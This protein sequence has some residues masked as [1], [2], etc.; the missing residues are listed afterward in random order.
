MEG[1]AFGQP[2]GDAEILIEG[3]GEELED[4]LP[5][6]LDLVHIVRPIDQQAAP[7]HDRQHGKI[8]PVIPADGEGMLMDDLFHNS[9]ARTGI[10]VNCDSR[11]A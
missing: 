3:F 11:V 2:V 7:D 5:A 4:D 1:H 6:E 10:F 8:D 9:P